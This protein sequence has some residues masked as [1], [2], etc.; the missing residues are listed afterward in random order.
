MDWDFVLGQNNST[1]KVHIIHK[2]CAVMLNFVISDYF[3][4][5]LSITSV[6]ILD[7]HT[8]LWH[9]KTHF[10][11]FCL[12]W[13]STFL[14]LSLLPP[15]WPTAPQQQ[16]RL[17]PLVLL[18]E[19]VRRDLRSVQLL[20]HLTQRCCRAGQILCHRLEAVTFCLLI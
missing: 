10:F 15:A 11:F 5:T 14:P 16:W 4:Q 9:R 2:A 1:F 6:P 18:A 20:I 7:W 13:N 8:G 19:V 12:L 3:P 17:W